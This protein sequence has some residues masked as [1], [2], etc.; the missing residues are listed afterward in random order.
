MPDAH[1]GLRQQAVQPL[2]QDKSA[3]PGARAQIPD[4]PAVGPCEIWLEVMDLSGMN[5]W[6]GF[7]ISAQVALQAPAA[8]KPALKFGPWTLAAGL[9]QIRLLD[10]RR[11]IARRSAGD[12]A[13]FDEADLVREAHRVLRGRAASE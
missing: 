5:Q 13:S 9:E 4:K 8:L 1:A 3:L 10:K 7:A 2:G 12:L 6:N 11:R